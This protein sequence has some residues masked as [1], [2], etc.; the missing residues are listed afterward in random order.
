MQ[1]LIPILPLNNRI[2]RWPDKNKIKKKKNVI[3]IPLVLFFEVI[4]NKK[5]TQ[6][7]NKV[8]NVILITYK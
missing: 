6:L 8:L 5:E 4:N 3:K 1:K 2:D 7:I